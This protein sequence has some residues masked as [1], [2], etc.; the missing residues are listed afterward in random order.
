MSIQRYA[1][2]E[3]ALCI[4]GDLHDGEVFMVRADD[5]DRELDALRE[6]RDKLHAMG[7]EYSEHVV[8]LKYDLTAA[9]QRN[10]A[11]VEL[12]RRCVGSVRNAGEY[13]DFD[14]P[15]SLME[16]IDAALKPTE[17]GASE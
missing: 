9:E 5:H 2:I 4:G 8:D 13:G 16:E 15:V 1:V 10:S 7:L 17:S 11:M 12:L 14:L 3:T 6:D